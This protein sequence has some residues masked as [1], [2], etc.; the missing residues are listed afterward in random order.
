M[1]GEL[2]SEVAEEIDSAKN[3]YE[4]SLDMQ[5]KLAII[6]FS[7]L[8]SHAN[9]SGS[10]ISLGWSPPTLLRMSSKAFCVLSLREADRLASLEAAMISSAEDIKTT[11]T[12]LLPLL[13][14][15]ERRC[16]LEFADNGEPGVFERW[17]SLDG[18]WLRM[19][20]DGAFGKSWS[21]LIDASVDAA[22]GV[23]SEESSGSG[24]GISS[25]SGID[26]GI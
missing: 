17:E 8:V 7:F 10:K 21:A 4:M 22:V 23:A 25:A 24:R 20:G 6:S 18:I 2:Y 9:R 3:E 26:A 19:G 1:G 15:N 13:R 11:E 12:E 5:S 14:V 16:V